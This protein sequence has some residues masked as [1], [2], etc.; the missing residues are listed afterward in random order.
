MV[1][2]HL[3]IVNAG[4]AVIVE[5]LAACKTF[6]GEVSTIGVKPTPVTDPATIERFAVGTRDY[7]A[8]IVAVN[9]L[10]TGITHRHP[11]FG[12]L[13]AHGWNCLAAAHQAIHRRQVERILRLLPKNK[14]QFD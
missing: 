9:Y 3:V 6:P 5:H 10:R 4:I 2:E 7:A 8:R 11:W 1:L 12:E 14:N 13:D